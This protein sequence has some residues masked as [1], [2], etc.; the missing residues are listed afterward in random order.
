MVRIQ[1]QHAQ[2]VSQPTIDADTSEFVYVDTAI[3][4]ANHRN[5]PQVADDFRP[6]VSAVDCFATYL[7]Y[8]QAFI[9][10]MNV[11][12]NKDGKHTVAGYSGPSLGLF[13]PIDTD[14]AEDIGIALADARVLVERIC[15]RFDVNA[16]AFRFYFSGNKGFSIEIPGRLFGGFPILPARDLVDRFEILVG[17]FAEGLSTV[18]QKIYDPVR[19]WRLPNTINGK[20]GLHKIALSTHEFLHLGIEDI[21]ELA[22]A[23]RYIDLTPEDEWGPQGELALIWAETESLLHRPRPTNSEQ[24]AE[25]T[26]RLSQTQS[27]TL[28]SIVS[29]HWFQGQKHDL[30]LCLAGLLATTGLSEDQTKEIITELSSDDENPNDRISAVLGTFERV[31]KGL[32]TLGHFGLRTLLG[33]DALRSVVHILDAA[34]FDARQAAQS[35]IS[36]PIE[37]A[38]AGETVGNQGIPTA[39]PKIDPNLPRIDAGNQDLTSATVQSWKALQDRNCPP[40]LF[41]ADQ[42]LIRLVT[43]AKGPHIIEEVTEDRLHYHLARSAVWYRKRE[44]EGKP[45]SFDIVM[46]PRPIAKDMMA[47]PAKPLPILRKIVASPVFS[48]AGTI[49]TQAGYHADTMMFYDPFYAVT[50]PEVSPN[51]TAEE[52]AEAKRWIIDDLFV[53]FPFVADSD[54]AHA[55]GEYLLYPARE[56]I[57]GPT[58][59]HVHEAPTEGTGKDLLAIVMAQ[60]F[61]G[62]PPSTLS[63]GKQ[64][65]DFKKK[66]LSILLPKPE[67]IVVPNVE[68]EVNN[69]DLCDTITRGAFNE[70]IL[71]K[72]EMGYAEASNVWTMT[73]N[74]AQ[75]SRDY[76]RRS[77]RIRLDAKVETPSERP[78]SQFHHP[79]L[80]RWAKENRAPLIWSALTLIQSWIAAGKPAGTRS[81][82]NFE[83]W[84]SVMGGILENAGIE[85]FLTNREAFKAAESAET[86][87]FRYFVSAW[88]DTHQS[89]EKSVGELFPLASRDD[90]DIDLG[91]KSDQS[92]RIRLGK[93][94]A[95]NRDRIYRVSE[96]TS[97]QVKEAGVS[98]KQTMWQLRTHDGDTET[99]A[100]LPSPQLPTPP[101]PVVP[102]VTDDGDEDDEEEL[103]LNGK[104][105][106]C[107]KPLQK[108]QRYQCMKCRATEA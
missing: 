26:V 98:H 58:P 14:H 106:R 4:G 72:S 35:E 41:V 36:P 69:Q 75:L 87:S 29:P 99:D 80:E 55:V 83:E 90:V 38:N 105:L 21:R 52:I 48:E 20:S 56:L 9:E 77:V 43:S 91:D 34:R 46:P 92:R 37:G 71:G 53:D 12:V 13:L 94:I 50:I 70:R 7:R 104:C 65:E 6:R 22:K 18:D 1:N 60:V 79:K 64:S 74:N 97:V 24:S 63:Y 103:Y 62:K 2:S 100:P 61:C 54:R 66:L 89:N 31:R 76:I 57:D 49:Q 15:A 11:T 28:I 107:G 23:P 68:G 19:L 108:G 73:A 27:D 102:E 86:T 44:R 59:F 51:P 67:W 39:I 10:H 81:L 30:A 17:I 47:T 25:G 5:H 45:A 82:G 96:T 95:K 78:E 16:D 32:P 88:W 40:T 42:Q 8:P 101:N 84:A 85:G 93:L 3:G 33:E